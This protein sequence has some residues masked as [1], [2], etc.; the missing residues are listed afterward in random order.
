VVEL[1]YPRLFA[2]FSPAVNIPGSFAGLRAFGDPFILHRRFNIPFNAVI[3]RDTIQGLTGLTPDAFVAQLNAFLG[4]LG[5]FLPVEFSPAT[6]FLRQD[7]GAAFRDAVTVAQPFKTPFNN[8]FS[9]GVDRTLPFDMV[10]GATYLH[11]E[12]R[13]IL[14]IRLTNLDFRS[15]VIGGAVTTDG[16]PIQRTY[17]GWY[18]GDYDA[19]VVSVNKRF[20]DRIQVQANYTYARGEDNLLN[21]NLALGLATQGGGSVPT[22]N[23]DLEFDR[24]P[25]DLLVPHTFVASGVG[26][27]PM[28]FLVSGVF[29]ATSGVFFSAAGGTI[30]YD[31]DG[32]SSRRPRG[33][34]RNEFNGPGSANL[35]LRVEK[36]FSFGGRYTAA[37]LIEFFN[38]TNA[39]NPRLIDASWVNGAP[40]PNFGEVLVPLPGRETQL[41][42][43]LEF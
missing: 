21:S 33:T 11:R 37:A 4:A 10:A 8:T 12:I 29:R 28:D 15:R 17:G 32:I 18:D 30:D 34:T 3:S 25:S 42:F 5:R 38:L 26:H 14:G 6:G 13:N 24:G 23:L 7:L 1:D 39:R 35:D 16:Q 31:G 27:L 41:G 20:S 40:G 43:R 36:R 2:D 19:F 22:D 9:V